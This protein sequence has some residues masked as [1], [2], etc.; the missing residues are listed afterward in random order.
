M[1]GSGMMI[2][3]ASSWRN[4][5]QQSVVDALWNAGHAVY[6]FK[7][8]AQGDAGFHWSEID[9]NWQ[10]WTTQQ[11]AAALEHEYAK[12]G[13]NRDFEA[14]KDSDACVLVLPCGRSANA[15]AGWMKGAGKKVFVY[16][17][18]NVQIEPELMYKMFDGIFFDIQ[19]ILAQLAK[20]GEA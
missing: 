19:D 4:A 13:F 6:D 1:R 17:P 9:P 12:F 16:I 5:H 18:P 14:M 20:G 10:K 8:P 11:Y 7:H 15:E 2:Y 3:V